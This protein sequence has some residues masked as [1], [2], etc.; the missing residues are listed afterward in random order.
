MAPHF[1]VNRVPLVAVDCK[2]MHLRR[3][4]GREC[5][6]EAYIEGPSNFS[7]RELRELIALFREDP[8]RAFRQHQADPLP[9][10][11]AVA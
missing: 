10:Q 8:A 11:P 7:G 2:T 6:H 4:V 3:Y 5:T 1:D 9:N